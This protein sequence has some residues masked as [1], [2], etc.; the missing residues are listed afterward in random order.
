LH[1]LSSREEKKK[2]KRKKKGEGREGINDPLSTFRLLPLEPSA[3]LDPN[4][5]EK[6]GGEGGKGAN[7]PLIFLQSNGF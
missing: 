4:W 5:E 2:E 3:R 7:S 1:T 6:G